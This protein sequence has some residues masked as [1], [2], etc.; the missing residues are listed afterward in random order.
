MDQISCCSYSR[1]CSRQTTTKTVLFLHTIFKQKMSKG[2]RYITIG[3]TA[4]IAEN[5]ILSE[6]RTEIIDRWDASTYHHLYNTCSLLAC[7]SI[8]Y[9]FGRY[10]FRQ[11]P[12]VRPMDQFMR[13]MAGR[14]VQFSLRF[15]G[16]GLLSQS[17]PAFQ[18]PVERKEHESNKYTWKARCPIDFGSKSS[19]SLSRHST[20]W[21]FGLT[22]L[23]FALSP[24]KTHMYMF[25]FPFLFTLI[26]STHIDDRHRRGIGGTLPPEKEKITSNVPLGAY[27][28]GNLP[29]S[30]L[31]DQL[32]GWNLTLAFLLAL[33]T[34]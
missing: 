2:L 5:L 3:W 7:G 13:S 21:A 32:K 6:Y 25:G 24:Y 23:S 16:L 28:R 26:G 1:C 30:H 17:L 14:S 27:M 22:S 19:Q 20:L 11:G 8:A 10:G 34:P 9:G 4:F 29:W 18:V 31:V 12:L 15:L 33:I